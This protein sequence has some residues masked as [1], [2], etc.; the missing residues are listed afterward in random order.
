MDYLTDPYLGFDQW[1]NAALDGLTHPE[2]TV[3]LATCGKDG[4]PSVRSVLYKGMWHQG[5][6]FYT[7]YQS[8]KAEQLKENPNA[9]LLFYWSHMGRQLRVEGL[10][11]RMPRPQSKQYFK[12]RPR[13][14]RLAA[15]ISPQS[16]E[17]PDRTFLEDA[18]AEAAKEYEGKDIPLPK[19]WGGYV[20]E[21]HYFEFWEQGVHRLHHRQCFKKDEFGWTSTLL[22][23]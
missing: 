14:S 23:P 4:Q 6:T 22:A 5:F 10:V 18:Y 11:K 1:Y 3:F 13:G 19:F 2:G 20:L 7:N 21:P 16:S 8:R 9:A 15:T 17:I 12:R